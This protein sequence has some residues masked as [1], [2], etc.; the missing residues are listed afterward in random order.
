[1]K[2]QRRISAKLICC[3]APIT[4]APITA[5]RMSPYIASAER[6]VNNHMNISKLRPRLLRGRVLDFVA[7]LASK[8]RAQDREHRN[9]ENG[10]ENRPLQPD[11]F[12][13]VLPR[14][15]P[16]IEKGNAQ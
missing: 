8:C 13:L 5:N 2:P 12:A 10:D 1:M 16:Q 6:R 9:A 15:W 14:F 7:I 3:R 11:S 4:R